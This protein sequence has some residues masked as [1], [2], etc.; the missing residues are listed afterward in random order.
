[1]SSKGYEYSVPQIANATAIWEIP[2]GSPFDNI[3]NKTTVNWLPTGPYKI[4]TKYENN[5]TGCTSD[6]TELT[7]HPFISA[8]PQI[9]GD[10]IAC[11]GV[12]KTYKVNI[13]SDVYDWTLVPA[14]AGSIISD[15]YADSIIVIF[16]NNAQNSTAQIKLEGYACNTNLQLNKTVQ[17]LAT[18]SAD[19]TYTGGGCAGDPIQFNCSLGTAWSWDFGDGNTSSAQNPTHT[20]NNGGSYVVSLTITNP[21]NNGC[22]PLI[23]TT[24]QITV[25]SK[26]KAKISSPDQLLFCIPVIP[27]PATFYASVQ[28]NSASYSYTWYDNGNTVGTGTTYTTSSPGSYYFIATPATGCSLQSTSLDYIVK[29]AVRLVIQIHIV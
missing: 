20:F 1:M 26:A 23:K 13:T 22:S 21:G 12:T 3:G 9:L 27:A 19:F 28:G 6:T 10:A 14:S 29:I 5:T 4:T 2:N 7:V 8:P 18:P 15:R 16:N 25:N 24:K 11:G 17:V